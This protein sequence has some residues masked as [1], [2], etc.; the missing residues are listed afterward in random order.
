MIVRLLGQFLVN[1][2]VAKDKD[3]YVEMAYSAP[4]VSFAEMD[5]DVAM[6]QDLQLMATIVALL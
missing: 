1:P 2:P 4:Y 5:D 3:V 6:Q